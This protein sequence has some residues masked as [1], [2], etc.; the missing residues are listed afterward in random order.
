MKV[1]NNDYEMFNRQGD[2]KDIDDLLRA[3][4]MQWLIQKP[5]DRVLHKKQNRR[6]DDSTA[7]L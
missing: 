5:D 4:S 7:L 6:A 3:V 2:C 1:K